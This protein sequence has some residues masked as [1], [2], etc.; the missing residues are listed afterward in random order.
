MSLPT[1]FIEF[2]I[3]VVQMNEHFLL[4]LHYFLSSTICLH[5][6]VSKQPV[7]CLLKM[8]ENQERSERLKSITRENIPIH[9]Y[10]Y[11]MYIVYSNYHKL[12]FK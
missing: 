2:L 8:G 11:T 5:R 10:V 1:D 7:L 6:S 4:P 9:R 3:L 12:Q